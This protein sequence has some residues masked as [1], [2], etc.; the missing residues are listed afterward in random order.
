MRMV[1]QLQATAMLPV[2]VQYQVPLAGATWQVA[3]YVCRGRE[4]VLGC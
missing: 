1:Q 3:R 2:A 4:G